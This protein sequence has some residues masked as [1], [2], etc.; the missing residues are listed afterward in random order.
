MIQI[1]L[2]ID[3]GILHYLYT[4]RIPAITS[5]FLGITAL[6]QDMVVVLVAISVLV[7]LVFYRRYADCAG[8][9]VSVFGSAAVILMLKYLVS[10][11]R[12]DILY[13]AYV[14]G[15]F[16]SFPSAHA[17]LAVALY[18]FLTYLLLQTPLLLPLP[19]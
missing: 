10:R 12:P 4:L 2:G 15:P 3:G 8:L 13:Q 11:P 18:G 7:V 5:L 9:A 6:G 17:G 14:E 16:Y 19:Y 1:L